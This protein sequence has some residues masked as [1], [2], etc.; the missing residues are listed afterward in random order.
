MIYLASPY[1]Y[2]ATPE[3]MHTRYLQALAKTAELTL[4]GKAVFS[5]IVSSHQLSLLHEMPT[6]WE[7]WSVVDY[8]F[9]D[10]S[11]ELYVLMLDCWDKSVGVQAEIKYAQEIGLTITYIEL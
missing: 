4:Q 6:T 11:S 8:A 9:L 2:K 1:S 7:F 3:L 5:P 10:A